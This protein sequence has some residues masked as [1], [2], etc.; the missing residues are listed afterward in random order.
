[1]THTNDAALS[2]GSLCCVPPL[3]SNLGLLLIYFLIPAWTCL[4]KSVLPETGD[5]AGQLWL[6]F[7]SKIWNELWSDIQLEIAIADLHLLCNWI[8][9]KC[10]IKLPG[11]VVFTNFCQFCCWT[12]QQQ[13]RAILKP[14]DLDNNLYFSTFSD[15][16]P[17]LWRLHQQGGQVALPS[18]VS[19]PTQA[20]SP[21]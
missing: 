20:A 13:H 1:M 16:C 15:R 17:A 4:T 19:C 2:G 12:M 18:Q 3:F 6:I 21:D 14:A 7:V 8:F 10:H 9:W 11:P 5:R